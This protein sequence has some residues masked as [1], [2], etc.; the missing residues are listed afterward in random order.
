MRKVRLKWQPVVP[1]KPGYP[2]RAWFLYPDEPDATPVIATVDYAEAL[3][4]AR[5]YWQWQ[6]RAS[7]HPFIC[8][9]L[10]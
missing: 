2:S 8:K 1:Y 6:N 10:Q 9:E 5:D 7:F 3:T 4:F